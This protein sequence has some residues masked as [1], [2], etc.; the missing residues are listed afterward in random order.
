[1]MDCLTAERRRLSILFQFFI[2]K[3]N[4]RHLLLWIHDDNT[5]RAVGL[6]PRTWRVARDR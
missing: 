5:A 3:A 1:M 4:V 2:R 6:I